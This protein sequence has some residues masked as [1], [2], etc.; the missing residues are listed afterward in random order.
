MATQKEDLDRLRDEFGKLA[1]KVNALEQTKSE[2]K[3]AISVGR[4]LIGCS[5]VLIAASVANLVWTFFGVLTTVARHDER[6]ASAKEQQKADAV[7]ID[8]TLDRLTEQVDKL[9]QFKP[10]SLPGIEGILVS[11]KDNKLTIRDRRKKEFTFKVTRCTVITVDG[12]EVKPDA[13]E[14]RLGSPA[15]VFSQPDTEDAIRVEVYKD[16]PAAPP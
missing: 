15:I 8:K 11:I 1:E 4:W 5:L 16:E 6:I 13:L 9:R 3:G 14:K 7:R 12:K 10:M 2:F